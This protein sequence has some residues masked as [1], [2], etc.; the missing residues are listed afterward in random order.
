MNRRFD[1]REGDPI[2]VGDTIR[3]D[4]QGKDERNNPTNG[5]GDLPRWD[6]APDELAL[7]SGPRTFNPRATVKAP[8]EFRVT[9]S[10]DD[11]ESNVLYLTFID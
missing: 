2:H 8:G 3:F 6:W 11:V 1:W 4:C 10:L 9:S 5:S 7:L